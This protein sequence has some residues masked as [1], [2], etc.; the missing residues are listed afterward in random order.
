MPRSR[1]VIVTNQDHADGVR[2][3]FGRSAVLVP[4]APNVE[5]DPAAGPGPDTVARRDLRERLGAPADAAVVA[6]FGFV[7]PVKGVRYL[8]AALADIRR[9]RPGTRLVVV[10][11]FASRALPEREAAAFRQELAARAAALGVAGAVTF[12]G[13]LPA[14]EVSAILAGADA[15]ALPFTA[16]VTTKSG[17]LLTALARGLPT[18]VTAADP[19]DPALVDGREAV[20]VRGVRD[21]APLA[22]GLRRVLGDP[23]LR[24][25]LA[26]GGRAFA[27]RR[28]WAA[29]AAAHARLYAD[30]LAGPTSGRPR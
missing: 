2:A 25:R 29:T 21:P 11:G 17:A 24:A 26:A 13:Y 28:T 1:A 6:F 22:A 20:V 19:P 30:V 10:G 4:L 23:A 16:G 14:G 5:T 3:R 8:L 12:T 27:R 9:E 15:C 18:V 7:H